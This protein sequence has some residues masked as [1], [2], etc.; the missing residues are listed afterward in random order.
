MMEPTKM[1]MK[2]A[3]EKKNFIQQG[4]DDYLYTGLQGLV[5][6]QN[7][8]ILSNGVNAKTNKKILRSVVVIN[9]IFP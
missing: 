6:R 3:I 2:H 9:H 7:H 1:E 5:M 4:Y 8:R